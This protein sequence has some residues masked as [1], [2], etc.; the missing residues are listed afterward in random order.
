[1]TSAERNPITEVWGRSTQRAGHW[2]ALDRLQDWQNLPI[3]SILQTVH[4]SKNVFKCK[5]IIVVLQPFPYFYH[6]VS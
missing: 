2:S 5:G 1:M 6:E 4:N 3:L